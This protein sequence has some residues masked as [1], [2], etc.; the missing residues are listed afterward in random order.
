MSSRNLFTIELELCPTAILKSE[1]GRYVTTDSQSA[2]LSCCQAPIW[3]QWQIFIVVR[4]LQVCGSGLPP[5][6]RGRF[7]SLQ[8]LLRLSIAVSLSLSRPAGLTILLLLSWVESILRPT[9]SRPVRLGIRP[10]F[11]AHDQIYLSLLFF[12]DWQLIILF[13]MASSLTRK[14]VCSLKCL[15]SLVRSLTTSNHTLPSHPR[16]CSLSVA[17]YDAQGLRWKHSNPP[18][19]RDTIAATVSFAYILVI[20]RRTQ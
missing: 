10:P 17:S 18:P 7:C 19:H 12:F 5:L 13:S 1:V 2:N 8:L 9:V 11:G 4:H 14:W 15:H 3:G 6:T 16:L 20:P